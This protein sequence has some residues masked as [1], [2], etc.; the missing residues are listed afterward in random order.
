MSVS[1][2]SSV[3]SVRRRTAP[4]DLL[5]TGQA[6]ALCGVDARTIARWADAGRV[7]T[8]RTVGGRRRV[9]RDDLVAFLRRQGMP[10]LSEVGGPSPRILV[11]DDEALVVRSLER[12]L[13]RRWPSAEVACAYN[14]FEAGL[15]VAADRPDVVLLDVVMPGVSGVE[16]CAAIRAQPSLMHTRVLVV[17]GHLS[18]ATRAQLVAVGAD[19]FVAK[20]FTPKELVLA[21]ERLVVAPARVGAT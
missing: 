4:G 10:V 11:V 18:P 12:I 20:P 6:A 15:R 16:V 13:W 8:H 3:P 1:S 17:S 2:A 9:R 14:G 7:P 19:G 21:V 5:T